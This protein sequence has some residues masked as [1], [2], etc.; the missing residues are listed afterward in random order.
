MYQKKKTFKIFK[1]LKIFIKNAKILKIIPIIFKKSKFSKKFKLKK[2]SKFSKRLK[3][4]KNTQSKGAPK[5]IRKTNT[6]MKI[7]LFITKVSSLVN[8]N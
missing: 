8:E 5:N 2:N 1:K 4:F 3:I 6:F 7:V